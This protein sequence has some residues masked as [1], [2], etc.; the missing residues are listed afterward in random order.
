[1]TGTGWTGAAF[2][3]LGGG[4]LFCNARRAQDQW[5]RRADRRR[6]AG[7]G[8][9]GAAEGGA[10]ERGAAGAGAAPRTP[11]PRAPP[12]SPPSPS[13]AAREYLDHRRAGRVGHRPTGPRPDDE[14]ADQGQDQFTAWA[15][16]A[17]TANSK[18]RSG[19]RRCRGRCSKWAS[20]KPWS[21]HF[22]NKLKTR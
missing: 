8:R 2:L 9:R 12:S 6:R 18:N 22:R 11:T 16:R 14:H 17:W 13:R 4:A 15:Y 5:R 20:A 1:M 19:R 7:Q 10:A 3:A 21:S